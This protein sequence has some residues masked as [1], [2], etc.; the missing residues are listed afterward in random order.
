MSIESTWTISMSIIWDYFDIH[1]FD[2]DSLNIG[3]IPKA[4]LKK[5]QR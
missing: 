2:V 4:N 5:E 3:F 1:L